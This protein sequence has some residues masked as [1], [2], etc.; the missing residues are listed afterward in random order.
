MTQH[1]KTVR[2][3]LRL[4]VPGFDQLDTWGRMLAEKALRQA[5]S[6]RRHTAGGPFRPSRQTPKGARMT[7]GTP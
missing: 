6:R 2:E 5:I 7:N 4:L 3:V 1:G